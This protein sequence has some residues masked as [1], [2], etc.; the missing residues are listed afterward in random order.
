VFAFVAVAV[1]VAVA[2]AEELVPPPPCP[3]LTASAVAT[4][5]IRSPMARTMLMINSFFMA[6]QTEKRS[7]K[8]IG[9]PFII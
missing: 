7:A 9:Y 4:P 1:A 5:P 2:G 6:R 3:G 8:R